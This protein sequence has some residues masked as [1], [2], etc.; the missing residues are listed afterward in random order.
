MLA[1]GPSRVLAAVLAV[2]AAPP[3]AAADPGPGAASIIE[4]DVRPSLVVYAAGDTT[5]ALGGLLQLHLAPWVGDD[6]QLADEDPAARAGFRLRRARLGVEA[7]L[8]ADLGFLLVLNPLESD[9]DAG[10]ISEARVSWGPRPW[11]RLW[12]GADKVPFTR[13]ELISSAEIASI[14]RPLAVRTLVP[15]RRLGAAAE[16]AVAGGALRIV[17][18]IMNAT[19][20]YE[21]GNQFSGLLYLGRVEVGLGASDALRLV[22]GAGGY[23]EDGPATRRVA[24]SANL[25]A[26]FLGASLLVEAL[27]DR[28]TPLDAPATSPEVPDAVRRCGG[29][30][31]AAYRLPR[32]AAAAVVRVELLDDDLDVDDAGDAWLVSAGVN[33]R[34]A[35]HLRLQ[36]HYLGRYER[37]GAERANDAVI[38]GL[39]GEL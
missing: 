29:Y 2:A 28:T 22:V 16:S 10:T 30:V 11:L 21:L 36:L 8:P 26:S 15:Q 35:A 5:L 1:K 9:P 12:A 27:C 13:G 39:Q 14:E 20:G 38:L 32:R 19:E 4:D 33:V 25:E 24:G 17:A 31:E 7:R 3:A 6:A 18:A 23:F 34:P 37:R